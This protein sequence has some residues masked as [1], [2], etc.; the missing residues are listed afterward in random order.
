MNKNIDYSVVIPVYNSVNSLL[1]LCKEL[2][3]VFSKIDRTFEILFINDCSPNPKTWEKLIELAN[4]YDFVKAI[5]LTRNFGQQAAT[6][7]GMELS[8]GKYIITMDDDLQHPPEAILKLIEKQEND[9]VIG[10]LIERKDNFANQI[11]SWIKNYFDFIVLGKPKHIRLS[12]F[13]LIKRQVIENMLNIKTPTPFIPALMFYVTKDAVN[14]EVRHNNRIEGKSNYTFRKRL[15]L[16]SL[17]IIN[18]SSLILKTL[19]Y[20]GFF[21]ALLSF[22]LI[23]YYLIT[24]WAKGVTPTGWASLFT[25]IMFFGGITLFSIGLIGEYLIRIIPNVENKPAYFIKE[26]HGKR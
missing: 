13:R 17:I 14:V 1:A 5:N 2:E 22:V 4:K 7:C 15:K 6:I 20:I 16:F 25:A 23:S 11:T 21:I 26:I 10:R 9:I 18:N 12:S 19:G 3:E 24:K 8:S